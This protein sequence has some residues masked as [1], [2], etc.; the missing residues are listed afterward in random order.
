MV[1][2][3]GISFWILFPALGI[4]AWMDWKYRKISNKI[5]IFLLAAGGLGIFWKF[6]MSW[7]DGRKLMQTGGTGLLLGGCAAFAVY[8]LSGGGIGAGDVKLLAVLGLWLGGDGLL[9]TVFAAA[10]TASCYSGIRMLF[11]GL[12][13]KQ[14]IPLAPFLWMGAMGVM[15]WSG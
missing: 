5:L 1:F 9:R 10:F 12:D 13:R 3:K 2:G 4:L 7:E 15:V 11:C 14:K 8:L 6:Q